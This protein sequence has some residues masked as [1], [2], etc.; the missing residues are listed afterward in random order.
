MEEVH[1]DPRETRLLCWIMADPELLRTKVIHQKQTWGRRC[2]KL[3][4]MSSK[5]DDDFPAIGK[6]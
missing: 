6:F 5:E 2:T 4:I 3:L 1:V